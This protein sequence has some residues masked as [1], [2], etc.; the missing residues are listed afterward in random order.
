M[1][2][3]RDGPLALQGADR[4]ERGLNSYV[5]G[6]DN[7]LNC[8]D[9]LGLCVE[10]DGKI[11]ITEK[12]KR[13]G[14]GAWNFVKALPSAFMEAVLPSTSG[15]VFGGL[16]GV[17]TGSAL[18]NEI[19]AYHDAMESL[20]SGGLESGDSGNVLRDSENAVHQNASAIDDAMNL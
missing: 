13:V 17:P 7:M 4:P 1:V 3:P 20:Q 8:R 10:D 9:P 5:M 2:G 18:G 14:R 15:T 19:K 12:I 11:S 6:N 16:E